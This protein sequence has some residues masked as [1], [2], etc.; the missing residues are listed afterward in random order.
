VPVEC[1]IGSRAR[2]GSALGGPPG[3]PAPSLELDRNAESNRSSG[4]VWHTVF[5]A[6]ECPLAAT[7]SRTDPPGRRLRSAPTL[8]PAATHLDSPPTRRTGWSNR[9]VS[10]SPT[11][12]PLIFSKA[13][14]PSAEWGGSVADDRA[15]VTAPPA[16]AWGSLL[17]A[18]DF[19]AVTGVGFD[20]VGQVFGAAVFNLGYISRGGK[21]SSS[22]SYASETDLASA[23]EGPFGLLLRQRYGA[24][25]RAL[26]RVIDECRALD[27]D[28]IIGVT[29]SIRPFPAG[30]TEARIS[31]HRVQR[32]F[33]RYHQESGLAK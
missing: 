33:G 20:P 19:T 4:S 14:K 29:L 2:R 21:C 30:G 27:A 7:T 1:P 9:A 22:G 31:K 6:P 3:A 15:G 28:G 23:Q 12:G 24:R 8:S 10:A 13:G 11:G 16:R 32:R 26:S 25:R 18:Q 5:L 17:S